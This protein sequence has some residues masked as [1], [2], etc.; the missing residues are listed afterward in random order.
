MDIFDPEISGV[1]RAFNS[2]VSALLNR[3]IINTYPQ[4][5]PPSYPCQL[6]PFFRPD[7][8]FDTLRAMLAS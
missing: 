7:I 6:Q 3:C 4:T 5:V 1:V 2:L 8:A